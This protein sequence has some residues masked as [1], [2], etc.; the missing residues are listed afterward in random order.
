MDELRQLAPP[1]ALSV[2]PVNIKQGLALAFA[3]IVTQV[4]TKQW[5]HPS[6]AYTASPGIFLML[7][8]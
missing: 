5:L 3:K 2:L 6:T 1:N 8:A 4:S 7:L